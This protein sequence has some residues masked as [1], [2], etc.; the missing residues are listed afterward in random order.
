M[1]IGKKFGRK[2]YRSD[3]PTGTCP[4][5]VKYAKDGEKILMRLDVLERE[6]ENLMTKK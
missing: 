1:D 6:M 4:T 2:V 5:A 3:I